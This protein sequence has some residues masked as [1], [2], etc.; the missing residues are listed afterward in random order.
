MNGILQKKEEINLNVGDYP[1]NV[2]DLSPIK[3]FI[4]HYLF[5]PTSI[6]CILRNK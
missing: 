5:N 6:Q 3:S 4:I 2:M 1:C